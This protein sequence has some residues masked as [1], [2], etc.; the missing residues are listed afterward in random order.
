MAPEDKFPSA[1]AVVFF[2]LVSDTTPVNV[3]FLNSTTFPFFFFFCILCFLED[4]L[5]TQ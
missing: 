4:R 2:L 5:T 1:T 3:P